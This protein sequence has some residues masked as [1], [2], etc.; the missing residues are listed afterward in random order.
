M[1]TQIKCNYTF[2]RF[3]DHFDWDLYVK[4]IKYKMN[5]DEMYRESNVREQ[6]KQAEKR[7]VGILLTQ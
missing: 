2:T 4:I 7:V 1:E 5:E 6:I 3:W